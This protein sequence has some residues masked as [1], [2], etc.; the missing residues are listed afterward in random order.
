[1]KGYILLFVVVICFFITG[2][3]SYEYELEKM[4]DAVRSH[5]RYRDAENGTK[6]T[7]NYLKAMS[8]EEIPEEKR[9]KPDEYYLCKVHIQG[10]WAYDNSYRIFNMNDTMNCYF[11]Q[12]KTFLRMEDAKQK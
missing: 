9:E 11:S 12:S 2:C 8:Y 7:V 5:M 3:N 10:T 4:G 6:T 1:M